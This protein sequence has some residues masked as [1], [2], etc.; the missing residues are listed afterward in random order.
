MWAEERESCRERKGK[1]GR[2]PRDV[3]REGDKKIAGAGKRTGMTWTTATA[4]RVQGGH[5]PKKKKVQLRTGAR[6][7][8]GCAG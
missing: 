1:G 8:R 5:C 4:T 2:N 3:G 6:V 7:R